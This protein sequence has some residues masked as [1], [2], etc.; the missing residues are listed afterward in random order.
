M[1][2]HPPRSTLFPSRRFSDLLTTEGDTVKTSL[3]REYALFLYFLWV[4]PAS[5]ASGQNNLS[6]PLGPNSPAVLQPDGCSRSEEHT[7]ELQSLAYLVCRL[8]PQ[9]TKHTG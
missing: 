4:L 7:A 9:K 8:L 3:P 2:R 6:P 5:L 1:I